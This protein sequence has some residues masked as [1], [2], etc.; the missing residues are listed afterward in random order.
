MIVAEVKNEPAVTHFYITK[1]YVV[2]ADSQLIDIEK[3]SGKLIERIEYN[4]LHDK[5]YRE[6]EITVS[7]KKYTVR[8]ERETTAEPFSLNIRAYF[9]EEAVE[10]IVRV[11]G[12]ETGRMRI[13]SVKVIHGEGKIEEREE[14]LEEKESERFSIVKKLKKW[15]CVV[16]GQRILIAEQEISSEKVPT[17]KVN[18]VAKYEDGTL[19]LYGD[20]YYVK[21]KIK[22]LKFS[23]DK[24]QKA[25]VKKTMK[26][27][28]VK[29]IE[30]IKEF[31]NVMT[32]G[33]PLKGAK[34]ILDSIVE[35]LED[36]SYMELKIGSAEAGEIEAEAK[37]RG[38]NERVFLK[39]SRAGDINALVSPDGKVVIVYDYWRYSTAYVVKDSEREILGFLEALDTFVMKE[40]PE[41]LNTKVRNDM[42]MTYILYEGEAKSGSFNFK[43]KDFAVNMSIYEIGLGSSIPK[44]E[45][46]EAVKEFINKKYKAV[47][48]E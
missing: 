29:L 44:A 40:I 8:I 45:I 33:E 15:Y 28:A 7:G 24:M 25:W 17:A 37:K 19:Y 46:E 11:E 41:K 26:E 48:L 47:G 13:N 5:E 36:K 27:E 43:Y 42:S 35:K 6:E 2:T 32:A 20:T 14:V 39:Y 23:W 18:I 22:A 31:A 30:K 16:K 12:V 34:N 1:D 4:Q 9:P 21:D 10:T 3:L 38:W